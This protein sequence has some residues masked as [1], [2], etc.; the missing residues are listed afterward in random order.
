MPLISLLVFCCSTVCSLNHVSIY[1]QAKALGDS[2]VHWAML[3][4]LGRKVSSSD[5]PSGSHLLVG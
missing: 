4:P 5:F 1:I 2:A 3:L